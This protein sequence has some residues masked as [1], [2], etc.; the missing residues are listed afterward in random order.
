MRTVIFVLLL[1]Y[2][3][4]VSCVKTLAEETVPK[5]NLQAFHNRRLG[6]SAHELLSDKKFTSL[7]VE[8]HY[9]KGFKP[10]EET[11]TNLETFLLTYLNKPHG[12]FIHLR[13]IDAIENTALMREDL[14]ALEHSNRSLF[15]H[16]QRHA[17]YVLFTNGDHINNKILGMA[18][19][20]TSAVIFGK[21]IRENSNLEGKLTRME[22][23]TA[24][25]LHE[26]GHLLGLVNKGSEM[27]SGHA[28]TVHETHCANPRCLMYYSTETKKLSLVLLKGN[29]PELD[30]DCIRD[31]LRNGGRNQKPLRLAHH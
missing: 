25:L 10:Q 8:I 30:E 3:P 5:I 6:E 29:I 18:Y 13:E 24:V 22:L 27:E 12:I 11:I 28:D 9:M 2:L 31:L 1:A 21:A 20:N 14:L 19:K 4:L 7:D 15:A 17:I 23:E 16:Q 26:M